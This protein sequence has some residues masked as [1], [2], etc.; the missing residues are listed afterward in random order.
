MPKFTFT[1]EEVP[2]FEL[3]PIGNYAFEVIGVEIGLGSKKTANNQVV[4]LK[5][6]FFALIQNVAAKTTIADWTKPIAQWTEKL[7]IPIPREDCLGKESVDANIFFGGR[8]NMFVKCAGMAADVGQELDLSEETVMGLRGIAY[9]GHYKPTQGSH[10]GE[11]F[12]QVKTWR[13]DM[14]KFQ[15]NTPVAA[16]EEEKPF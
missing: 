12:N 10:V 11:T 14:P 15:R 6:R 13:T 5:C 3:L 1:N 2:S 8:C 16:P 9:V 4:S 7:T